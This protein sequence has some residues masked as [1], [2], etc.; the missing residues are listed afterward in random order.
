[1][2]GSR[3]GGAVT[4]PPFNSGVDEPPP[5]EIFAVVSLENI[6][7]VMA[8]A[9]FPACAEA[10]SMSFAIAPTIVDI[11]SMPSATVEKFKSPLRAAREDRAAAPK[12]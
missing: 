10:S 8:R 5:P 6:A 3:G 4:L 1:M 9:C 7:S 12:I 2:S 11:S